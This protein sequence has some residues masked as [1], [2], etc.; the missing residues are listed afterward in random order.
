MARMVKEIDVVAAFKTPEGASVAAER[1]EAAG[2]RREN[3][4]L[5]MSEDTQRRFV[6]VKDSN[7]APE[8]AAIGG[9]TGGILGAIIAGVAAAAT[10]TIPG[11]GLITGPLV[12]ALAGAGAGA[13]AGGIIGGLVGLGIPEREAKLYENV[14][15]KGGVLVGVRTYDG[16]DEKRA[17][18]VLKD[19]GALSLESERG[20]A[21][22]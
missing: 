1:L 5:V 15:K 17:R 12:A 2:F 21:V 3:I 18:A 8:G 11:V 19:A 22:I 4:G 9:A 6:T 13:A 16:E 14:L 7:K 10:V 20:H